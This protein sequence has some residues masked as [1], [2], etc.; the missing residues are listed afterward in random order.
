[1]A[2]YNITIVMSHIGFSLQ[3]TASSGGFKVY[4]MRYVIAC[5]DI[6]SL[7]S[8]GLANNT[9]KVLFTFRRVTMGQ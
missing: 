4:L 8:V 9:N 5:Y 6:A 3:M 2:S 1:M 7:S